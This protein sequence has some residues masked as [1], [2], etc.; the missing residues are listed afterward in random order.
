VEQQGKTYTEIQ[1]QWYN[2]KYWRTIPD[3]IDEIDDL[4]DAFNR[5]AGLLAAIE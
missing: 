4:I 2:D 3:C 1:E 5:K